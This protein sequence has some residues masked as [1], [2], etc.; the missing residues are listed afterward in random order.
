ME[1][2]DICNNALDLVGQGSHIQSL[3]E[4]SK[5]ADL[6]R[7]NFDVIVKRALCKY[8]FNFARKD[9][10]ITNDNL[11]NVV[12][13]P[14]QYTYSLPT[15]CLK[16]FYLAELSDS[17]DIERIRLDNNRFNFR[18]IANQTA[19]V[20]DM[21]APFVIE[22]QANITNVNLFSDVFIE[23]LEYLL[24]SRLAVALIH[25]TS[26]L[27]VSQQLLNLGN[28]TLDQA[29]G[30]DAQQGGNSIRQVERPSLIEVRG[31]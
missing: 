13:L 4:Q 20:T 8:N 27:Q 19:L 21:Q 15:D 10:V 14:W 17:S 29:S 18:Q 11:L 24:A 6:C 3:D 7:R 23:G 26:G 16:I 22:Y 25:G 30:I 5:E 1:K 31:A 28:F 9:E 12:S 2:I